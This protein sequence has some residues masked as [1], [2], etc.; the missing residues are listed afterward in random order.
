MVVDQAGECRALRR[1][2]RKRVGPR[3]WRSSGRRGVVESCFGC[4]P[5]SVGVLFIGASSST[6][7]AVVRSWRRPPI[8]NHNLLHRRQTLNLRLQYG[9]VNNL[10]PPS[11]STSSFSSDFSYEGNMQTRIP[12]SN[13]NNP[14]DD[15]RAS[16]ASS[17]TVGMG[18]G[19]GSERSSSELS[20]LDTD[21]SIFSN[22]SVSDKGVKEW[23]EHFDVEE[24]EELV[25]ST[26]LGPCLAACGGCPVLLPFEP[27]EGLGLAWQVLVLTVAWLSVS[28]SPWICA[29]KGDPRPRPDLHL[30]QERRFQVKHPRSVLLY[31]LPPISEH[32][33]ES[34]L[35][36]LY[37]ASR[38]RFVPFRRSYPMTSLSLNV[39]LSFFSCLFDSFTLPLPKSLP[40]DPR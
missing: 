21:S 19:M 30:Y 9:H 16:L 2:R 40:S 24:D 3:L 34:Q 38:R 22:G 29:C 27:K 6:K 31:L 28:V 7:N 20:R 18:G 33:A 23:R 4:K 12:R 11:S 10:R 14:Y 8:Y 1:Q 36:T 32:N 39:T 17:T 15:D 5:P 35:F 13:G 37:Q 25:D 26:L